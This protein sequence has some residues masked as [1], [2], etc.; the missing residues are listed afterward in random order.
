M[1]KTINQITQYVCNFMFRTTRNKFSLIL[2]NSF[3]VN[4]NFLGHCLDEPL[5]FVPD[6]VFV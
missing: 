2:K 4:F 3:F 5:G 6:L 1:A